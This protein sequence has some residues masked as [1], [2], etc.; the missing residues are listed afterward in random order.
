MTEEIDGNESGKSTSAD[1]NIPTS[2]HPPTEY[3]KD[4]VDEL[5][6]QFWKRLSPT[7]PPAIYGADEPGSLFGNDDTASGWSL[8]NLDTCLHVLS[9]IP[10]VTSPYLFAGM[11]ASVFCAHAEDM[12]LLSINYLHAGQ[13]KFWYA[14]AE[15]DAPRLLYGTRS[16]PFCPP[17]QT[18]SRI[19]PTQAMHVITGNTVSSYLL[20]GEISV[21]FYRPL[22]ELESSKR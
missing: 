3:T 16:T 21:R 9:D 15:P 17:V 11:W 10:G 18:L 19:P 1:N 7:M 22:K 8:G 4:P 6:R 14:V 20:F 5:E 2:T 12:N 13:P